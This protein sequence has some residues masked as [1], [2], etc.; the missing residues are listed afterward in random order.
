MLPLAGEVLAPVARFDELV[1]NQVIRVDCARWVDGRLAL[2]GD[3]AHAMAPNLGQGAG[4]ALVDAAVLAWALCDTPDQAR[5]LA[6]YE[7]ERRGG[8]RP[9]Q[10]LAGR[11]ATVSEIGLPGLRHVRDLSVRLLSGWLGGE[12]AM[13]L[14]EQVNP[15]WMRPVARAPDHEA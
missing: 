11:L 10:D 1:V 3:A 7:Q 9:V 4:S 14:A 2:I 12:L 8:V 6:A 5:A 15:L 13:R